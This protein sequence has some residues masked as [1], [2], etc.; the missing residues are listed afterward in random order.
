MRRLANTLTVDKLVSIE[1]LS[2]RNSDGFVVPFIEEDVRIESSK[3]Y[4]EGTERRLPLGHIKCGPSLN[5]MLAANSARLLLRK[6]NY[7]ESIEI[8]S[9]T[10]PLVKSR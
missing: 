1:N 8:D 2:F 10:A 3:L 4:E 5:P 7:P 6:H 9:S